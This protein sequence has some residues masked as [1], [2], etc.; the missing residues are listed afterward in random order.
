MTAYRPEA[1]R[2]EGE[3]AAQRA[4]SAAEF[5]TRAQRDGGDSARSP[6]HVISDQGRGVEIA[7]ETGQSASQVTP[8]VTAAPV[9]AS[10]PARQPLA[11]RPPATRAAVTT[12][13]RMLAG[14]DGRSALARRFRDLVEALGRELGDG[15]GEAERL[16]VRNAASMQLHVEDLTARLARGEDVEPEQ[17]TRAANAATRAISALRKRK[18]QKA[19]GVGVAAYLRDRG[20]RPE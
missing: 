4:A 1:W 14:V 7:R 9:S 20:A 2:G 8:Q 17:F 19:R 11:V 16:M 13:S 6:A 5:P 10:S 18:P 12:G 15:L 3:A